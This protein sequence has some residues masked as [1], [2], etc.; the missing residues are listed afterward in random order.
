MIWE[1]LLLPACSYC[2][3][4]NACLSFIYCFDSETWFLKYRFHKC[5]KTSYCGFWSMHALKL[6][7]LVWLGR[8]VWVEHCLMKS[9]LCLNLKGRVR[10]FGESWYSICCSTNW[11]SCGFRYSYSIFLGELGDTYRLKIEQA[12]FGVLAEFIYKWF[13]SICSGEF[14]T[15]NK[16]TRFRPKIVCFFGYSMQGTKFKRYRTNFLRYNKMMLWLLLK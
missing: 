13:K 14:F 11:V 7:L 16:Q 10:R 4:L 3:I 1:N 2:R 9:Q 15:P 5:L 8:C 6:M 12:S